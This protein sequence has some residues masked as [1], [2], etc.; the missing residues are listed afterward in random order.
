MQHVFFENVF[1]LYFLEFSSRLSMESE[2]SSNSSVELETHWDDR[3][4]II[5]GAVLFEELCNAWIER[6]GPSILRKCIMDS[7]FRRQS[8]RPK[9]NR[10]GGEFI[11]TEKE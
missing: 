4:R 7:E 3:G 1:Y 5:V 11:K 6:R 9:L 2:N 10:S 8:K